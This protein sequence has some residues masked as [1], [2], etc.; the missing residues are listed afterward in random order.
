MHIRIGFHYGDVIHE[1]GDV[2]GDTVNI[3]ARV[4][5]ITRASQII[6]TQ[7]VAES[8]PPALRDK[9][10][11]LVRAEFKGKPAQ[12]DIF[13]VIWAPDEKLEARVGTPA[14]RKT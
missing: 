9:T 6:V 12:F 8:L 2:F 1:S 13:M 4:A 5:A 3:A 10:R 7:T 11:K 14:Q